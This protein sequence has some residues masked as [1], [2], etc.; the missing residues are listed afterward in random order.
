MSTDSQKGDN[1]GVG[2][3]IFLTHQ[4]HQVFL[5]RSLLS[6]ARVAAEC[7]TTYMSL[8]YPD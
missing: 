3:S 7:L 8:T 6:R 1:V 5:I 2:I 4:N